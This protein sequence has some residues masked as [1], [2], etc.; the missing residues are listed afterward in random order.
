MPSMNGEYFCSWIL[1]CNVMFADDDW[2]DKP[3]SSKPIESPLVVPEGLKPM[4]LVRNHQQQTLHS[5][6]RDLV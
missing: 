5:R 3:M 2:C 6:A 4:K 1:E